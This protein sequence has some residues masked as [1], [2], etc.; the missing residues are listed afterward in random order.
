MCAAEDMWIREKKELIA[1]LREE[2]KERLD[3]AILLIFCDLSSFCL[4]SMTDIV[5]PGKSLFLPVLRFNGLFMT[6]TLIDS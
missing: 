3:S 4:N 2:N 5:F 1:R 6:V